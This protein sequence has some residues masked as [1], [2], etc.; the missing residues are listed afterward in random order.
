[1]GYGLFWLG[2]ALCGA[3]T[4]LQVKTPKIKKRFRV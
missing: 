1:M 2:N 3:C 4:N